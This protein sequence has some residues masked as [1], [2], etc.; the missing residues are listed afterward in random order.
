MTATATEETEVSLYLYGFVLP[1]SR[2]PEGLTGVD[3]GVVRL[4]A[5]GEVAALVSEMPDTEIVGRPAEVRAHSTVLD[6]VAQTCSVLPVRFGTAVPDTASL[7]QVATDSDDAF[8]DELRRLA[9]VVQ[10]SLR[11]R[12]IRET[13]IAELVDEEPE[14][15][16]LRES[17]RNLS[18]EA[19]YYERIRLG[20]LIV[21]GFDRKRA[22]DASA[23]E[24][25]VA[26]FTVELRRRDE[27]DVDDVLA[28]ALLVRRSELGRFEDAL[29]NIAARSV[30]RMT[31][32][33]VGPQAP[34]DFVAEA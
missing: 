27:A 26:P 15:R 8:A 9:D 30:D 16:E 23:L 10:L 5:V 2:L 28:A 24:E 4:E 19:S 32:R 34:Y 1:G 14:I 3:D 25:Q 6:A 29:E 33:L 18:E 11:V 31:F 21:A 20:E 13:V 22:A 12:Y 17:T 7:A